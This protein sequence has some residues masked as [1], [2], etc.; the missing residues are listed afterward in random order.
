MRRSFSW[1]FTIAKVD[2]PILGA[3]FLNHFNLLIN[4]REKQLIDGKTGLKISGIIKEVNINSS[5]LNTIYNDIKYAEIFKKFKSIT[6]NSLIP[7]EIMH[8]VKHEIETKGKPVFCKARKIH[9]EKLKLVKDEFQFLLQHNIIRPSKSEWSSPLHI[10]EKKEKQIRPCGDYR[11]LNNQTIKDRYPVPRIL[12]FHHILKNTKIFSKI[13]LFKAYYQVPI[14]EDDIKKTAIIT[15]FGLF[16]YTRMNFGLC[17]ASSTFQRLMNSILGD[18]NFVFP[19][20]DDI[21]VASENEDEHEK[22]LEIVFERLRQNGLKI[23][24]SKS[25]FGKEEIEFL[26]YL[27]TK[28]G[29]KPLPDKVKCILEYKQP[30]TIKELRSFLGLVNFYRRYLKNAANNQAL[31]HEYLKGTKKNDLTPIIWTNEAIESFTKT[32]EELINAA[33]LEYPDEKFPLAL[34]TDASDNAMGAVIQ[35]LQDNHWKPIGFFSKKLNNAQKSYSAY[36]KELLAI[37]TSIKHFKYLLEAR[38]FTIFTDHKPLTFAFKQNNEKASPRQN[39]QL[40]FISEFCTNIQYIKGQDNIVAD[41]LSRISNIT[42]IDYDEIATAQAENDEL[43]KFLDEDSSLELKE[44]SIE[45]NKTLWCD[46]STKNIRPFIPSKLRIQIYKNIHELAHPSIRTTI[47]QIQSKYIWPN[48]KKDITQWTRACIDCQRNK[49]NK[50]NK[51]PLGSYEEPDNKFEIIHLDIIGPLPP[52]RGNIYCLTC[53]D[54]F[55]NWM[56]VIPMENI[57]AETVTNKFYKHWISRFG[58]PLQII[59]DQGRQFTSNIFSNLAQ[60]CGIKLSRT[61]PYHPQCNGK[62]ERLHRTLKAAIRAKNN[63][64]WSEELPTILLGMRTAIRESQNYSIAEMLYGKTIRLPGEF[65]DTKKIVNENED[66]YIRKLRNTFDIIKPKARE[67]VQ[68]DIFIHKDMETC[69][70]VFI[71]NDRVKRSLEPPYEGPFKIIERNIKYFKI[72]INGRMSN[73]SIDRL[74]PAYLLNSNAEPNQPHF[75]LIIPENPNPNPFITTRSGRQVKP[76]VRY[77][78]GS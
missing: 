23:N 25:V 24:I 21:L 46:I 72:D 68:K 35:Q 5:S 64:S 41:T 57:T 15:P 33:Q 51:T 56:E 48:M 27:L 47:K 60:T 12:D 38:N 65:I 73:I 40:Q 8:D 6:T 3:D 36:D 75:Q 13:D 53:I 58:T 67:N 28:E 71:R 26:G 19:Y 44:F 22:H 69:S 43:K 54:R 77:Q 18:L 42:V 61:T 63:I 62:I 20:I 78:A 11:K 9:P 39:R 14:N 45:N 55:T 70:H 31:L 32:K 30:S 50:H 2:T 7:E 59:T 17:N 4:L 49:V 10:A 76:P 52:S 1:S 16:E 34:F 37:Y 66:D 74:K 29:S